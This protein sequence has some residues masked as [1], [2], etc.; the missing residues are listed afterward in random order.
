[1]ALAHRSNARRT[2]LARLIAHT[3]IVLRIVRA[4]ELF[5]SN[6][7]LRIPN[8]SGANGFHTRRADT[9]TDVAKHTEV[10]FRTSRVPFVVKNLARS[11]AI[12]MQDLYTI[13]L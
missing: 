13:G 3:S 7:A 8:A 6:A 11:V 5:I 1:M 4:V 2:V 12:F 10:T 9:G